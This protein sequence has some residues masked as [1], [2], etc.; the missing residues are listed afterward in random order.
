MLFYTR[1]YPWEGSYVFDARSYRT[2]QH[3]PQGAVC[4][5]TMSLCI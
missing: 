5:V 3:E 1:S 4:T 2:P